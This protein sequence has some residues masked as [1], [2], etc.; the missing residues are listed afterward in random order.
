[1][2]EFLLVLS[3]NF[4][5]L[6]DKMMMRQRCSQEDR[7]GHIPKRNTANRVNAVLSLGSI[8][9]GGDIFV[10]VMPVGVDEGDGEFAGVVAV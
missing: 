8:D 10:H 9:V 2:K 6:C 3:L 5:A 1:M 4:A 7:R